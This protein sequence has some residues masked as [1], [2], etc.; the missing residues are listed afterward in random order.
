LLLR[1]GGTSFEAIKAVLPAAMLHPFVASEQNVALKGA[2]SPGM[3]HK[4]YAPNA[5]MLLVDGQV[6][7]MITKINA[8][9]E[10]YRCEGKKVGVLAT[11]ETQKEYTAYVV[12]S[13]GSRSNLDTVANKLFKELR[14]FN[15]TSVD[16][17]LAESVLLDGM[18]LAVMNRLRKASN[19]NIIKA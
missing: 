18:G 3:L 1:P 5:E 6:Q 4:H 19:Y 9:S 14:E 15:K 2:R 7:A 8:L 16:I 13:M 12:K 11:D 10:Q 17:I